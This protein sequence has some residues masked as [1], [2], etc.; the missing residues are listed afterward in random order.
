MEKL[1]IRFKGRI[2][3]PISQEKAL[4]MVKRGQI[5]RQHEVSL[6]GSVWR[7]AANVSELFPSRSEREEEGASQFEDQVGSLESADWFA[8][9]DGSNQGPTDEEGFKQWISMG[10]VAR[11]TMVWRKGMANWVEAGVIQ[12]TWFSGIPL[13][14]ANALS[15][16]GWQTNPNH[17]GGGPH[18]VNPY[19]SA[20]ANM[21]TS[22]RADRVSGERTGEAN[23]IAIASLVA[24]VISLLM[25]PMALCCLPFGIV[26][27]ISGLT[28]IICGI[29]GI[30]NSKVLGTGHGLALA[31]IICG[32]IA[33]VGTILLGIVSILALAFNVKNL[34]A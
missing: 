33:I 26:P 22:N 20:S 17:Q 18:Y 1:Y 14:P 24:G 34:P 7:A 23:G 4:E 32:S 30:S 11:N 5:T 29:A 16:S 9:F 13:E 15:N 19:A 31:G 2:L 3:G 6:D 25:S 8:H 12:P 21:S 10:K 28:A 27:G